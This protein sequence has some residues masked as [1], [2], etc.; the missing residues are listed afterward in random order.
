MV[1]KTLPSITFRLKKQTK[2]KAEQS[3]KQSIA[4]QSK[5]NKQKQKQTNTDFKMFF[6]KSHRDCTYI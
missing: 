3:K 6:N 1:A 4:K 5:T 2:T